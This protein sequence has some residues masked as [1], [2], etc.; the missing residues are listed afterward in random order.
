MPPNSISTDLVI[1]GGGFMGLSL[2]YQA[3]LKGIHSIILEP[4][5]KSQPHY[6]TG[7][8]APRADYL[9]KDRDEVMATIYECLRWR[10]FFRDIIRPKLYVMPFGPDTPYSPALIGSLMNVYDNLT[11]FRFGRFS[12]NSFRINNNILEQMEQNLKKHYFKEAIGFYELTAQP[13]DLLLD[14]T[15]KV[16]ATGLSSIV[17]YSSLWYYLKHD[18]I[19]SVLVGNRNGEKLLL[20]NKSGIKVIN[21]AGPWM[22]DVAT[23]L[24]ISLPVEYQL[25]FQLSIPEKYCFQHSIITFGTDGLYT[26]ISQQKDHIQV[27]PTNTASHGTADITDPKLRQQAQDYLINTVT[28]II[29]PGFKLAKSEIKSG[30]LRVKLRLPLSPDSNRPFILNIGFDNY[31]VVYPGK[32]VMALKTADEFLANQFNGKKYFYCLDGSK[33]YRNL[34]KLNIIRLK[35]VMLLGLGLAI[36]LVRKYLK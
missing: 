26:I 34:I 22:Q 15:N 13:D 9:S 35:S 25:G 29:E 5:E 24:G 17:R 21:T 27:G 1:I 33:K 18:S 2:A 10:K 19:R 7:L 20:T 30:G 6:M 3:S 23:P 8:F 12:G 32:A 28:R 16:M 11:G 31:H 36:N 4:A 14:F